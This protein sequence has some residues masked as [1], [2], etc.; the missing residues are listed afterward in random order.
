[1]VAAEEDRKALRRRFVGGLLDR[2]GPGGDLAEIAN[3]DATVASLREAVDF[4]VEA[5]KPKTPAIPASA[6]RF[7]DR[8]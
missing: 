4:C 2:R 5:A 8:A 6:R 1:V 7:G 3:A